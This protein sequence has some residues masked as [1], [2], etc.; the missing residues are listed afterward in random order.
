[1][2]WFEA[3]RLVAARELRESFR[4]KSLWIVLAVLFIGSS[5]AMILPELL[6][7]GSTRYDVAVV[8]GA[9]TAASTGFRS[10][11]SAAA[12]TL[13]AHVRFR[14]VSD[15]SLARTLVDQVKVDIAVVDG[16]SLP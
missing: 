9:D 14:T 6:D 16:G 15:R 11:L 12:A 7:S 4:R 13:D 3:T 10:D 8:P 1:V 5:V 2:T